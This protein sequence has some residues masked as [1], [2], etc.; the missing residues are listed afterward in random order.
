MK[1]ICVLPFMHS[2]ILPNGDINVCCNANITDTMPSVKDGYNNILDNPRHQAI[3]K[4]MLAGEQPTECNRCWNSERLGIKSYRQQQN[5]TYISYFPR[6]WFNQKH[7]VKFFDVRFNN[8]CNLK[9]VMCS[10]GYSS[11]WVDDERKLIPIVKDSTLK[12]DM[13][14]R[15]ERY[16]K[17][18]FKWSSD[19]AIVEAIIKNASKLERIHFAGGEPLLSKQHNMLIKELIRLNLAPKLFLSYN[20]NGEFIDDELLSLW[21]YF[22]RVKVFYSLDGIGSKN[23]YIRYPSVWQEH[24]ARLDWIEKETPNNIGWRILTTVSALNVADL[25]EIADWK[26]TKN[27]KKIHNNLLDGNLFHACPLEHPKYLNSNV[28]PSELKQSIKGNVLG[29]SNSRS[30]KKIA[31]ECVNFMYSEDRSDLLPALIEYLDSL[32]KLRGTDFRK[33]F[34]VLRDLP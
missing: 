21:S 11:M 9:C 29:F 27:Y 12:A 32:D 5:F 19:E 2:L 10:S 7:D 30:Y 33:V 8:T 17:D 26:L 20:T 25:P 3:R 13:V 24:N 18:A 31:N 34:P 22:K 1:K 6:M 28:L 16:D 23:D 14:S 15:T 4:Q